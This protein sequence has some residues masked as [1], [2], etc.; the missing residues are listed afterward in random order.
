[1]HA[2]ELRHGRR[3]HRGRGQGGGAAAG[4]PLLRHGLQHRGHAS[5]RPMFLKQHGIRTR[6]RRKLS[7]GSEEILDSIRAGYV[8]YVI[9]TRAIL[10]GVHYE[11]GV[12]IRRC[13]VQNNVTM[14]H[15]AGYR[16]NRCWTCWRSPSRKSPPSTGRGKGNDRVPR[17]PFPAGGGFF[18][19]GG[20]LTFFCRRLTL[21]LWCPTGGVPGWSPAAPAI[22]FAFCPLSPRPLPRRGRG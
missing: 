5:A 22:S 21:P 2:D 13:A 3:H 17:L 8:S 18:A 11:D 9:N 14:L 19:P 16:P 4:P 10:S 15:L 20:G 7:E 1:M 12:A 6:V